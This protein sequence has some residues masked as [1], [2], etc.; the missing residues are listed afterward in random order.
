MIL[1]CI[2]D[3]TSYDSP[4]VTTFIDELDRAIDVSHN[5][6]ISKQRLGDIFTDNGVEII[7]IRDME[8]E[9]PIDLYISHA[10]Q[11]KEAVK[12]IDSL[13]KYGLKDPEISRFPNIEDGQPVFKNR[14]LRILGRK[15]DRGYSATA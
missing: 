1:I 2:D 13:V 15:E 7:N 10:C 8:F 4:H 5:T 9:I 14:A 6:R 3:L 12:R 11:T